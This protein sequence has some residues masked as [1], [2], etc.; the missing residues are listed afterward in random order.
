MQQVNQKYSVDAGKKL[1]EVLILAQ[2]HHLEIIIA[3]E[4]N[5]LKAHP[6]HGLMKCLCS[7]VQSKFLEKTNAC[8]IDCLSQFECNLEL[9]KTAFRNQIEVMQKEKLDSKTSGM[10]LSTKDTISSSIILPEPG[11]VFLDSTL[12]EMEDNRV[13]GHH[14]S[15]PKNLFMLDFAIKNTHVGSFSYFHSEIP[16][17]FDSEP[18]VWKIIYC[19]QQHV[20]L[21]LDRSSLFD[22]YFCNDAAAIS[23][24]EKA[25]RDSLARQI[26]AI[27]LQQPRLEPVEN[28]KWMIHYK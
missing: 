9:G 19:F 12:Y 10:C 27:T 21:I 11:S 22:V 6:A 23:R 5:K 7:V 2:T 18:L 15:N 16:G 1:L 8:M 14:F 17:S 13:S 28:E 4:L 3:T 25:F 24:G 20:G 26:F